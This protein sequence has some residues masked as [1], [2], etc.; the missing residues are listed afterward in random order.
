MCCPWLKPRLVRRSGWKFTIH[1][2]QEQS[3]AQNAV[4][5][6][7]NFFSIPFLK[8]LRGVE[9]PGG[10]LLAGTDDDVNTLV[11]QEYAEEQTATDIRTR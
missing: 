7:S 6:A 10:A 1:K 2:H 4:R 11:Y 9:R 3:R 5:V 8:F